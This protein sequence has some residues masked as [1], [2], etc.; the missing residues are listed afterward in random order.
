MDGAED[1]STIEAL[2][3]SRRREVARIAAIHSGD[4][5]RFLA[6]RLTDPSERD[7][8]VQESFL[9]LATYPSVAALENPRAFLFRI[10]ENLVRDRRRRAR[11]RKQDQHESLDDHDLTDPAPEPDVVVQHREALARARAAILTLDE[12]G[13][14][15]FIM[16]RYRD[17]SY[18]EIA[19]AMKISVKTVEKY[20]SSALVQLRHAVGSDR[21]DASLRGEGRS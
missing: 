6:G 11:S 16:S 10:A 14:T 20:V 1:P 17:M 15:A 2:A 21:P 13:R 3:L 18:A 9:R 12:P 7:E 8:V 5:K 19:V 4:L